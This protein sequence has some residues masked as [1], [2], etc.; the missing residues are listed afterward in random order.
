MEQVKRVFGEDAGGEPGNDHDFDR[1]AGEVRAARQLLRSALRM[2][3]PW[4]KSEGV[5]IAAI[6]EHAAADI[7]RANK[8]S[9]D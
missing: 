8:D 9:A 4:T 1:D 5:R 6:L 3:Y 2:K 7:L